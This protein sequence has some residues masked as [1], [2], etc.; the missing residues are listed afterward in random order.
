MATLPPE[1]PA[2]VAHAAEE[3]GPLPTKR[4]PPAEYDQAFLQTLRA[5]DQVREVGANWNGDVTQFPPH[6]NWVIHPNGDLE[7]I[8]FD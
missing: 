7:R 3:H 5:N 8:G 2:W 4:I 1:Q 6:V